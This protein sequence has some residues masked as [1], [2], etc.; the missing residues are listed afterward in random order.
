MTLQFVAVCPDCDRRVQMLA[1]PKCGDPWPQC[2]DCCQ[3][4][5]IY[6]RHVDEDDNR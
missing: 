5:N 4:M 3:S 2:L 1:L 6:E